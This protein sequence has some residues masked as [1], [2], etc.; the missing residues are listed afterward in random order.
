[1]ALVNFLI[2]QDNRSTQG[3]ITRRLMQTIREN[4]EHQQNYQYLAEENESLCFLHHAILANLP[5][6]Q[7]AHDF[8]TTTASQEQEQEHEQQ[9]QQESELEFDTEDPSFGNHLVVILP[10][11]GFVWELDSLG[12]QGPLCLGPADGDWT[13][14]AQRRLRLWTQT[15]LTTKIDV[16]IQAIVLV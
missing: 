3:G 11:N 13:A 12:F 14:V 1:M 15:T 7:G 8:A 6:D 10:F 16:D 9:Q 4:I 5:Y 2:N